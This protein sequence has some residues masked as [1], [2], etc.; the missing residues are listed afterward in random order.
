MAIINVAYSDAAK[1]EIIGAFVL[2][3]SEDSFP[4]QGEIDTS[5]TIWADFYNQF[6]PEIQ[7][8]L[9]SPDSPS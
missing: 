8:G 3:Q 5:S 1:S 6:T 4:Y 7:A 9:P 2:P